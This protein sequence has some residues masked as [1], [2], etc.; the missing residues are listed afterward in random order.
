MLTGPLGFS[1]WQS[2]NQSGQVAG[3]SDFTGAWVAYEYYAN[4]VTGAAQLKT[5]TRS[6]GMTGSEQRFSTVQ[7]ES[8]GC[9][10]PARGASGKGNWDPAKAYYQ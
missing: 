8:V 5:E 4:G 1:S 2:Y 7:H 6:N 10:V 9:G 3:K